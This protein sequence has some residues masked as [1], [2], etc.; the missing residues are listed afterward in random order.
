MGETFNRISSLNRHRF[1]VP[2]AHFPHEKGNNRE[3]FFPKKTNLRSFKHC[4]KYR[5]NTKFPVWKLCGKA[6]F[7]QSFGQIA[8]NSAESMRFPRIY[9]PENFVKLRFFT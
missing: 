5:N 4:V 1:L 3:D 7:P 6:Q 2:V 9:T 8:R